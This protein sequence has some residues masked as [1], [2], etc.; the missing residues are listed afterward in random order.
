MYLLVS[1]LLWTTVRGGKW[2][3]ADHFCFCKTER[4][5]DQRVQWIMPRTNWL[6][7]T[8][9]SGTAGFW[10]VAAGGRVVREAGLQESSVG[11]ESVKIKV[12]KVAAWPYF[13]DPLSSGLTR[14]GM[15]R[16][17]PQRGQREHI[18]VRLHLRGKEEPPPADHLWRWE[19]VC[20]L[21]LKRYV[22]KGSGIK[23]HDWWGERVLL[24]RYPLALLHK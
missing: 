8:S 4:E 20:A 1:Y 15:T 14:R 23:I 9:K 16:R 5:R 2:L 13:Q 7:P 10:V 12:R 3:C 21:F 18:P 11:V 22:F 19:K 6:A 17:V 24:G